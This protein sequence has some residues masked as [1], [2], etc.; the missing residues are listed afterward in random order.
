MQLPGFSPAKAN[1]LENPCFA[2]GKFAPWIS[3]GRSPGRAVLTKAKV[4]DCKYSALLGTAEPPAVDKLH[5]IKQ[6]VLIP[7]KATLSWW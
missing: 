5:G 3:I 2:T 6:K 4:W 7:K 1:K